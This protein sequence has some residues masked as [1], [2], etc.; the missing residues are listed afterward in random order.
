MKKEKILKVMA[1]VLLVVYAIIFG[2]MIVNKVM[3]Q[4]VAGEMSGEVLAQ[5]GA[6]VHYALV[7]SACNI[8]FNILVLVSLKNRRFI[9]PTVV[10]GVVISVAMRFVSYWMLGRISYI[11]WSL[12]L[13]V[14]MLVMLLLIYREKK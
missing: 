12:V 2:I 10:V 9:I 5:T 1:I 7:H 4:T 11:T 8:L 3:M 13:R 14:V 6:S